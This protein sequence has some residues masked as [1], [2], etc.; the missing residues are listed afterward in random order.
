ML[1]KREEEKQ[2]RAETVLLLKQQEEEAAKQKRLMREK[3]VMERQR[4]LA[5][6]KGKSMSKMVFEKTVPGLNEEP[7]KP[8]VSALPEKKTILPLKAKDSSSSE[9]SAAS[10]YKSLSNS[11]DSSKK[12]E[13]EQVSHSSLWPRHLIPFRILLAKKITGQLKQPRF[14]MR[15]SMD[16]LKVRFTPRHQTCLLTSHLTLGMKEGRRRLF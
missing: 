9:S 2:K 14:K 5:A 15:F 12:V 11:S 8:P 1:R 3:E 10:S 6:N 7:L 16:C 4:Q 13:A